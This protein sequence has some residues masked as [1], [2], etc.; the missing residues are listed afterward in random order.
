MAADPA[1]ALRQIVVGT[2][3]LNMTAPRRWFGI[4]MHGCGVSVIADTEGKS[5]LVLNLLEPLL[6]ESPPVGGDQWHG[7]EHIQVWKLLAQSYSRIRQDRRALVALEKYVLRSF[8]DWEATLA[9]A[10][11]CYRANEFTK[12]RQYAEDAE[13]IR[14]DDLEG[15]ALRPRHARRRHSLHKL[16][17]GHLDPL[18]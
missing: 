4:E 16:T 14:P 17:S 10:R 12:A 13:R 8:G 7:V 9:L 5:Y 18:P 6:E 3:L 1:P 15:R 11:A 2:A